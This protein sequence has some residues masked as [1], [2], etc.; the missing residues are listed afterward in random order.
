MEQLA[1]PQTFLKSVTLREDLGYV[2]CGL[3]HRFL[4]VLEHSNI[5]RILF[6]TYPPI[7]IPRMYFSYIIL[8]VIISYSLKL[9]L[10]PF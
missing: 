3:A 8:Y 4:A 9:L 1:Q 10:H 6:L 2:C 5:I 7:H